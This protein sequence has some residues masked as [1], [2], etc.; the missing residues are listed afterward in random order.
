MGDLLRRFA[1]ALPLGSAMLMLAACGSSSTP[2]SATAVAST[3]TAGSTSATAQDPSVLVSGVVVDSGN[4]PVANANVECMGTNVACVPPGTQV[5]TQDGPDPGVFTGPDG[6][7]SMVVT[8]LSSG[9]ILVNAHALKFEL[10]M[11]QLSFPDAGCSADQARCA[12]TLNFQLVD[13][14]Q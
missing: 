1:G 14:A 3:A 6:R 9:P 10:Q 8:A 2:T 7:Y 11:Q 12:L 13:Q 4:R 5:I